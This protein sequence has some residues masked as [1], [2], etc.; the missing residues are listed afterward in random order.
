M[1]IDGTVESPRSFKSDIHP[2]VPANRGGES[3]TNVDVQAS[4]G[5]P[6]VIY[7]C[8][9]TYWNCFRYYSICFK[10]PTICRSCNCPDQ[11]F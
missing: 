5:L 7:L 8:L 4:E 1:V 6:V 10:D 2:E 9:P 3:L 11:D